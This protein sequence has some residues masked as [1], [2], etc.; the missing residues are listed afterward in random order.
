M[1]AVLGIDAAWTERQPSGVA[2]VVDNGAGW[3]LLKIAAS[4]KAFTETDDRRYARHLGSKPDPEAILAAAGVPVDLIAIGMPL[5]L[6]PIV[7]RRVSDNL[8][9]SLY[10]S[11]HAGTHTPS[12]LRPGRLS[13]ELRVGFDGLGFPLLTLGS[14]IPALIEVY[15]HPALIELA[16]AAKR[17]PYKHGKAGK[18][19]PEDTP[20]ARRI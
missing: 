9:S 16:A 19:W 11:R 13:D 10:G 20:A 2:L 8:I 1:R 3:H 4:Y 7:G 5:S 14:T 12:S 17:L 15:P 6:A 18:Y